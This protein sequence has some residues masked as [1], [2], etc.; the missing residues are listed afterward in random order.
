MLIT[1]IFSDVCSLKLEF[2]TF[3]ILG[4]ADSEESDGYTCSD[5]CQVTVSQPSFA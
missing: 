4:I 5:K 1:Y 2:E 3:T